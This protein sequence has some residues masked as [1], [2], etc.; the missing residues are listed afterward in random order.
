MKLA[1]LMVGA[2]LGLCACVSNAGLRDAEKLAIYKAHAGAPV[3]SFQYFGSINSW[4]SLGDSDIA[5]W[6]RPNQAYLLELYGPCSDIEF[7]PVISVTSQ[8]G[9]V[10]ARFDK[11][12]A[13][14]RGSIEI[15][16]TIEQIRPLDVKAIKQAEKVAREQSATAQSST[17]EPPGAGT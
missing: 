2:A 13:H 16:C 14:N 3:P 17:A 6:T 7:T 4:T 1:T 10:N 9:R 5:V 8:M 11:V 12:I 15:P